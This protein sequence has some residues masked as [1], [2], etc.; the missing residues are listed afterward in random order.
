M[1]QQLKQTAAHLHLPFGE[2]TMTYNSRLAQEVG[3]WA[4]EQGKGDLFHQAA[5]L[6][7]FR[8]GFN[9]AEVDTLLE[10]ASSCDLPED[11]CLQVI[12][13]RTYAEGVDSDWQRSRD[14]GIRAVPTLVLNNQSL[15]GFQSYP[16]Y[17][18]FLHSMGVVR[19]A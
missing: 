15:T 9:L 13:E 5:F 6:A 8:D 14:L 7:Y 1:V 16:T 3:L 18:N 12:T 11:V 4:E 10:L 17:D 2:R 19:Q